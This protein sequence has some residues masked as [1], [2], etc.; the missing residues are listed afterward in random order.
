MAHKAG[1]IAMAANARQQYPSSQVPINDF[2]EELLIILQDTITLQI[3]TCQGFTEMIIATIL[4]S[5][6][7]VRSISPYSEISTFYVGRGGPTSRR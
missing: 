2:R 1:D 6:T 4:I 5:I 3:C 7:S